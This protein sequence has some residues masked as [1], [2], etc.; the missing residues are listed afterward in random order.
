MK[1]LFDEIKSL[2]EGRYDEILYCLDRQSNYDT[3]KFTELDYAVGALSM[4]TEVLYQYTEHS[5]EVIYTQDIENFIFSITI[6][7]I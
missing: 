4:I 5:V 7:Q 6:K 1:N 2:I 3:Y